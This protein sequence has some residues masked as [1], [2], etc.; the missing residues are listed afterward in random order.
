MLNSLTKFKKYSLAF[1]LMA[2]FICA[3]SFSQTKMEQMTTSDKSQDLPPPPKKFDDDIHIHSLGLGIGQA[4]LTGD[5]DDHGASDLSWDVLY[6]YSASHSFD[7]LMNLHTNSYSQGSQEV[8]LFALAASIKGK[9]FHFDNFIPFVLGGMGLYAPKIRSGSYESERKIA[10]GLNAGAG[11]DLKLN[12]HF[13]I[14]GLFQ[15]HNPFDVQPENG[16]EI[17]GAYYKLLF[18]TFYSF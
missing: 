12:R 15:F 13:R 9:F 14:G 17:S 11:L 7:L 16:P 5:F 10:F 2:S 3:P 1:F 6:N 8:S 4:Y 18:T